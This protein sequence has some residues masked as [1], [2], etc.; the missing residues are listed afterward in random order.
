MEAKTAHAIGVGADLI[1]NI[2]TC[3][4]THFWLPDFKSNFKN[5][6]AMILKMTTWL[7]QGYKETR[8]VF[9]T[10]MRRI[11]LQL[12]VAVAF[13]A[14][15]SLHAKVYDCFM[16][17]NEIELLKMRLEELDEVVDY[18][19]LV[20]S[21]E[22]QKG[23][24]KSLF[25]NENRLLFEKYLPKIIHVMIE[26]RHPEMGLWERENYQRICITRGL[27]NCKP[28][29]IILISD[30]DEI[31]RPE[32]IPSIVELLPERS[33]KLLKE[34][35]WK[36]FKKH[37][38]KGPHKKEKMF[39]LDAARG[40]QMPY[41]W[42]Q[43]NRLTGGEWVGTVATTYEMVQK[44][45]I[46]HFRDYRW[47]FPQ[48]LNSGWH[49]TWMGGKDKIRVKM[50]SIVEGVDEQANASDAEIDA[51]INRYPPS[52]IDSSFPKYVQ[53]NLEYLKAQGFIA[54]LSL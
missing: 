23:A 12:I 5:G 7:A 48:I 9:F 13:L 10:M 40:F 17:F 26:E 22:T 47:K 38:K 30:L 1:N 51:L 34:G 6:N 35:R 37:T 27:K 39:Y 49:F 20:E 45:G 46:Q 15:S 43:L 31:P 36:R 44:F 53:R 21:V 14:S 52:P 41:Y 3:K 54:D 18:F 32:L 24:L 28:S 42:Y 2:K 25:F 33:S 19:V 50:K 29:D 16:F 4:N 8:A 11:V